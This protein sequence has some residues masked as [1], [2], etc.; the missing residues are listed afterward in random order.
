MAGLTKSCGC[1][2]SSEARSRRENLKSQ[3]QGKRYKEIPGKYFSRLKVHAKDKNREFSITKKYV[4][5][6][7]VEQKRKCALSGVEITFPKVCDCRVMQ[8][9][10][11]DRIDSSKGYIA[12]NVQWIHK[13]L[14]KI[15]SDF[16][17]PDFIKWCLKVAENQKK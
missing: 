12:G 15:K 4:W 16:A 17:E 8:T 7:F 5:D 9:A 2:N 14:N 6:K 13:D 3:L 11:L 1:L 10:S